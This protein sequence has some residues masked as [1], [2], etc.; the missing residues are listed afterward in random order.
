MTSSILNQHLANRTR[1][2]WCPNKNAGFELAAIFLLRGRNRAEV[3]KTGYQATVHRCDEHKLRGFTILLAL[4]RSLPA[5]TN[6]EHCLVYDASFHSTKCGCIN[7]K[8]LQERR[9]FAHNKSTLIL[10]PA[11]DSG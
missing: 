6:P 1:L 4:S 5:I 10:R 11:I 9:L 2:Y 3:T 8:L 7:I